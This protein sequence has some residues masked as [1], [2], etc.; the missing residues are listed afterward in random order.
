MLDCKPSSFSSTVGFESN[1]MVT[2]LTKA[3][4]ARPLANTVH[5]SCSPVPLSPATHSVPVDYA[6]TAFAAANAPLGAAYQSGRSAAIT[7]SCSVWN[8]RKDGRQGRLGL[9]SSLENHAAHRSGRVAALA[10]TDA[11]CRCS[12]FDPKARSRRGAKPRN[13]VSG[14]DPRATARGS[15]TITSFRRRRKA[16]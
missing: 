10:R 15:L 11:P 3:S 4:E 8:V 2:V 16:G 9:S 5:H 14:V 12:C 6:P 13:E 1:V 7:I